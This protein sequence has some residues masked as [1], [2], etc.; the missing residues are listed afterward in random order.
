LWVFV[1]HRVCKQESLFDIVGKEPS[2][3]EP[4]RVVVAN[5]IVVVTIIVVI[6]ENLIANLKKDAPEAEDIFGTSARVIQG[7]LR[8]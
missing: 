7:S 2:R 6:S 4:W 5:I 1:E 3:L 8:G